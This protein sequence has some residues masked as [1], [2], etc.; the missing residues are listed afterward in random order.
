MNTKCVILLIIV[1]ILISFTACNQIQSN[2]FS[3]S[4]INI[5]SS[6]DNSTSSV[7]SSSKSNT[8]ETSVVTS[9]TNET[10]NTSSTELEDIGFDDLII[11]GEG[12]A[13]LVNLDTLAV[14][15]KDEK[16]DS[17]QITAVPNIAGS[18]IK[19]SKTSGF[20]LGE[21]KVFITI[22]TPDKRQKVI[23]LIVNKYDADGLLANKIY[24]N[25]TALSWMLDGQFKFDYAQTVQTTESDGSTHGLSLITNYYEV[26][27]DNFTQNGI[28]QFEEDSFEGVYK[29]GGKVYSATPQRGAESYEGTSLIEKSRD[30]NSVTYIAKSYYIKE[31]N[32][33]NLTSEE[34]FKIVKNN[35]KWLI[36]EF[37]LDK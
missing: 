26:M 33:G 21:N 6:T 34:D 2:N 17:I 12:I 15:L 28:E 31:L 8:T 37:Y 19:Y 7:A 29:I 22:T 36:D 25:A 11:N 10:T 20:V 16:T 14:S 24:N 27:N 18:V 32:G 9:S 23:T 5:S 1:C 4:S 30:A 13:N 3:P 35:G